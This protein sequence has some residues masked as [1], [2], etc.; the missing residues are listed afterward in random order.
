MLSDGDGYLTVWSVFRDT[1]V[2]EHQLH[3]GT[4]PCV[5]VKRA[6]DAQVCAR[7]PAPACT[8]ALARTDARNRSARLLFPGVGWW[9]QLLTYCHGSSVTVAEL[10]RSIQYSEFEGEFGCLPVS[11]ASARGAAV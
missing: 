11:R 10:R 4:V 6:G 7:R 2:K 3:S 9:Y 8:C 1:L 5:T